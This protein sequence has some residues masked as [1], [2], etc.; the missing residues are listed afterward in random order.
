LSC[1]ALSHRLVEIGLADCQFANYCISFRS[2]LNHV[3]LGNHLVGHASQLE[4]C[5]VASMVALKTLQTLRIVLVG[6]SQI[7]SRDVFVKINILDL[8]LLGLLGV[9]YAIF[10]RGFCVGWQVVVSLRLQIRKLR[11]QV[12]L[13]LHYVG[14][15][16]HD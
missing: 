1:D 11:I 5:R 8:F 14:L 7:G 16:L 9:S 12:V 10:Q 2:R 15:L 4:S 3:G 13:A 6:R